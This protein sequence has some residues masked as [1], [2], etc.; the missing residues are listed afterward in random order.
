MNSANDELMT[1]VGFLAAVITVG[2]AVWTLGT[3]VLRWL[4]RNATWAPITIVALCG[5]AAG[6]FDLG[7]GVHPRSAV[8]SLVVCSLFLVG[9]RVVPGAQAELESGFRAAGRLICKLWRRNAAQPR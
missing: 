1:L 3:R 9:L 5:V 8:A 2:G 7:K 6:T 4:G